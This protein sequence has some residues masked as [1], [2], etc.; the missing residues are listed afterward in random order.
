MLVLLDELRAAV[1]ERKRALF[2]RCIQGFLKDRPH[3]N[4]LEIIHDSFSV[5]S[6]LDN[7]PDT[8]CCIVSKDKDK[9]TIV[10]QMYDSSAVKNDPD[11]L[12]LTGQDVAIKPTVKL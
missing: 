5:I 6:L 8:S 12:H 7:Y 2:T 9:C 1:D 3:V 10:K 4:T 11:F